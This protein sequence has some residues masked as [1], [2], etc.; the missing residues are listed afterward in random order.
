LCWYFSHYSHSFRLTITSRIKIEVLFQ[1]VLHPHICR[2]VYSRELRHLKHIAMLS[3]T[4]CYCQCPALCKLLKLV[5][6]Y[7]VLNTVFLLYLKPQNSSTYLR[8]SLLSYLLTYFLTYLLSFL[9][10]YLLAHSLTHSHTHSLTHSHTH[11]LTHSL[12]HSIQHSP[13][14]EANR[15]TASQEIPRI[16]WNPKDHYRIH[17]YSPPVCI[18]S[19]PNP[20]HTPTSHVTLL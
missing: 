8:T 14:S 10:T 2:E 5:V 20:V 13:F 19:Q 3:D 1:S 16:L 6:F 11:S 12:T 7:S 17:K 9:L 4:L 18:L 15:F